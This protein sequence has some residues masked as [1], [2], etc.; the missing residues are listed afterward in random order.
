[1]RVTIFAVLL[2]VA[3]AVAGLLMTVQESRPA[4]EPPHEQPAGPDRGDSFLIAQ[5][6]GEGT[7]R[8]LYVPAEGFAYRAAD[9]TLTGVTVEIARDF[10]RWLE[11]RHGIDLNM[12][13][14]E[15]PDWRTFYGRVRDATG[16]VMGLGNVTIT[17]ERRAELQF[18]SPYLTNVAVLITHERVPELAA[19]QDVPDT[20]EGLTPL[21]FEGT[22]H[23]DRL[24][25]IRERFAPDHRLAFATS[26][27]EIVERVASGEYYAYVDAYNFWRARE[28]GQPLRHHP[29]G[30]DPG[31]EF[32]I[33]LPL[34]SDWTAPLAAFFAHDGGYRNAPRYR[35]LLVEHLGEGVAASLLAALDANG[36]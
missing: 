15:E 3:A 2:L 16:G 29:V 19:F 5:A 22:L 32:G 25:A 8:V 26:N 21:A 17:E 34:D 24:A 23:E 30:D 36:G 20:F 7:V 27:D 10:H 35:N 18:S 6:A 28:R 33:I 1:M 14:V 12:E 31:E 13:F 11:D 9:G 4:E